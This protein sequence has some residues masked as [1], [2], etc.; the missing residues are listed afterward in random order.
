MP[1]SSTIALRR[2]KQTLY[3]PLDFKNGLT[4]DALVDLGA[5]VSAKAQKDLAII[6]RKPPS[7]KLLKIDV[8]PSFQV[9]VANGRLKKTNSNNHT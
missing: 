8:P 9:Q 2:K 4:K 6:K 1:L 3:A 7:K 5:Y